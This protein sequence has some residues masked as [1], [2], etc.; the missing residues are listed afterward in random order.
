MS[1]AQIGGDLHEFSVIF[2]KPVLADADVVLH[3][4]PHA[5]AAP[6]QSHHPRLVAPDPGGRPG[7]PGR[8]RRVSSKQNV[9]QVFS[10]G[11]A[12]CTPITN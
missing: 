5:V 2:R 3:P 12:F 4:G 6:G 11:I 9:E 8:T 1:G 10:A 7:A